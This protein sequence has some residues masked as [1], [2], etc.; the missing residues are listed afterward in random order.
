LVDERCSLSE[1]DR[2]LLRTKF[3]TI[4]RSNDEAADFSPPIDLGIF[5]GGQVATYHDNHI[6][7]QRP[8]PYMEEAGFSTEEVLL[9]IYHCEQNMA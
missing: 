6:K 4:G 1:A 7:M 9:R 8:N 5:S 3:A 2:V